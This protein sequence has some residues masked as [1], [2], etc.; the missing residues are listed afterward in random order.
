MTR[1]ISMGPQYAGERQRE[2]E[3]EE[4][5]EKAK[6]Y[7]DR[8]LWLPENHASLE[9]IRYAWTQVNTMVTN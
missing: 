5:E 6:F 1:Y 8:A 7:R 3:K 9:L 2:S 4:R